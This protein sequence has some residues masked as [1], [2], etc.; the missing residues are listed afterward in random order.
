LLFNSVIFVAFFAVV[1]GLY[2]S[3]P[4]RAQNLMLLVASYVFYGSWDWRFLSLIWISTIVDFFCGR[5]IYDSAGTR[6]RRGYLALSVVT[7]LALLGFFKYC[8]FFSENLQALAGLFGLTLDRLTLE[9][10][11]PVGISFYTFQTLSY[12]IDIYRGELKPE[13]RFLDFALFVAFFPQLVAGPIERA[14]RL[15][16]QIREPRRILAADVESGLWFVFWGF[17]LKIFV[18]DNLAPIVNVTFRDAATVEGAQVLVAVYAFAFQIF[19][20]F[21]GYS[22]I[23]IG[24][25]KLMGFHLMTNFRFP[26]FVTNPRDFWRNWHISLS[27]WL[28]DYLYIPLGGSR[29]SRFMIYRNL[30]LTMLLGGL[31]HGA[32]W[33]FVLW[34]A[35]Q[36]AILMIHRV[37]TRHAATEPVVGGPLAWTIRALRILFMFQVTCLGWLIFRAESMTQLG[38]L[39]NAVFTDLGPP[40]RATVYYA[41][42]LFFYT[43]LMVLVQ[44]LQRWS[45]DKRGLLR[46]PGWIRVPVAVAMFYSLLVWG[47]FGG[48]EFIYFQF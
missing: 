40:S 18:A 33:T 17:F 45:R 13:R 36:G 16:P 42:Q 46:L 29:G 3:L 27:T 44:L 8:N 41:A 22:S 12:S 10:I 30:F 24:I 6:A 38:R 47:A 28:R 35:Y 23:A 19:G 37:A 32:A 21:A 43:W 7:N 25:G 31:W 20:D 5:A 48:Q 4:H 1:Y 26:Y 9:V 2:R 15:L 39:L 11:L 34:G 14:R